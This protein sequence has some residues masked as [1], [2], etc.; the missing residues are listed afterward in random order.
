M[1][2]NGYGREIRREVETLDWG[3]EQVFSSLFLQRLFPRADSTL[4]GPGVHLR[5][6][7]KFCH[8]AMSFSPIF[9]H[10]SPVSLKTQLPLA[11]NSIL[12][13]HKTPIPFAQPSRSNSKDMSSS[14]LLQSPLPTSPYLHHSFSWTISLSW[15]SG[16]HHLLFFYSPDHLEPC[17]IL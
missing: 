5:C 8:P 16:T 1:L 2:L 13:T 10:R 6:A 17:D 9:F 14:K 11:K 7:G 12:L 15:I 3:R 4:W